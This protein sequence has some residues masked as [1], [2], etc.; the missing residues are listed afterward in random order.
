[1]KKL[2]I[3]LIGCGTVGLGVI[4]LL[5]ERANFFNKRFHADFA[6]KTICDLDIQT[7]RIPPGINAKLTADYNEVLN[8]KDIEVVI[9]LIGG[10]KPAAQI[11]LGALRKG[12]HV[13]TPTKNS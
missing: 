8:D 12:K 6:V 1:M 5:N 9:E 13:I 7:K 11:V 10:T 2:N 4:K 3:G